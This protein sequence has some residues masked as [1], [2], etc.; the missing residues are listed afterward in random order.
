MY[1]LGRQTSD[2]LE[3]IMDRL[4]GLNFSENFSEITLH[5]F[6]YF[7]QKHPRTIYIKP[8]PKN[9][10][11]K[12]NA[13]LVKRIGEFNFQ[14][15]PFTPHLTIARIRDPE[16]QYRFENNL[17]EIANLLNTLNWRFP[18]VEMK[19]CATNYMDEKKFWTI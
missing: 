2:E 19:L 16:T 11:I 13:I 12:L 6:D 3:I 8:E 5:G 9:E 14:E 4:N 10:L 1:Y 7:T 15:K 18:L 17:N